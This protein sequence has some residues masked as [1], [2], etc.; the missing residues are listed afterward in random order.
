RLSGHCLRARAQLRATR[1]CVRH[2]DRPVPRARR[3]GGVPVAQAGGIRPTLPRAGFPGTS[4][5]VHS[6]DDLS[7]GELAGGSLQPLGDGGRAG[8]RAG[9]DSRVLC[10][11]RTPPHGEPGHGAI[12]GALR[13]ASL[14]RGEAVAEGDLREAPAL[15]LAAGSGRLPHGSALREAPP[16]RRPS[17][18]DTPYDLRSPF[19]FDC[20]LPI[21]TQPAANGGGSL[22]S[23]AEPKAQSPLPA[24]GRRPA[25]PA[26]ALRATLPRGAATRSGARRLPQR[27]TGAR[28]PTRRA[29]PSP[30]PIA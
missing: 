1:R 17:G 19:L 27:A 12:V 2:R 14:R 13:C 25:L 7:A 8:R 5:A 18:C 3:G 10:D 24:A 28:A 30:S 22:P 6:G 15:R 20:P 23:G 29:S 9:G 11:G 4:R 16:G 26:V 21:P